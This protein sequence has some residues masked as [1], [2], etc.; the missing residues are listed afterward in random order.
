MRAKSVYANAFDANIHSVY[1]GIARITVILN[2]FGEIDV[3]RKNNDKFDELLTSFCLKS[4]VVT[5]LCVIARRAFYVH[6]CKSE[7]NFIVLCARI[8]TRTLLVQVRKR[9]LN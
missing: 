9:A 6:T 3:N 5:C 2:K 1:M 8:P 7:R 4:P